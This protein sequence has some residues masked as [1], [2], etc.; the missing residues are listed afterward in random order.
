M[1]TPSQ[2]VE[3]TVNRGSAAGL[4]VGV[5]VAVAAFALAAMALISA[6]GGDGLLVGDP[7]GDLGGL[8]LGVVFLVAGANVGFSGIYR[9]R[10]RRSGHLSG[11]SDDMAGEELVVRALDRGSL[12]A[13]ATVG[14]FGLAILTIDLQLV[15]DVASGERSVSFG[16]VLSVLGLTIFGAFLLG[17]GVTGWGKRRP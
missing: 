14:V 4:L 10:Q 5:F 6:V 3:D 15:V 16:S 11:G 9:W 12:W 2:W 1:A 7:L 17:A 8:A 13:I